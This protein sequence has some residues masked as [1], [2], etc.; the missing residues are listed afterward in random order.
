M[1]WLADIPPESSVQSSASCRKPMGPGLL[2]LEVWKT[3]GL[4][5]I[6]DPIFKE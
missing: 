5:Y 3:V 2:K 6:D 4:F 1:P